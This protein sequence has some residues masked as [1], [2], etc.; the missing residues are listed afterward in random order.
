MIV[1]TTALALLAALPALLPP[2]LPPEP[3]TLVGRLVSSIDGSPVAGA[4]VV[5]LGTRRGAMS[6]EEGNFGITEVSPGTY[7]LRI[8]QVGFRPQSH[9]IV[10][11]SGVQ[12]LGDVIFAQ[13]APPPPLTIGANTPVGPGDLEVTIRPARKHIV[14][15]DSPVFEVRI[16]NRA[17]V[18]VVLVQSVD[19]SDIGKSP[20]VTIEITGPED[21]YVLRSSGRC[22][23]TNG[24]GPGDFVEVGPGEEFD[25]YAGGC[26][27][28][29]GRFE[30]PGKFTATFRYSTTET[31][32]RRW[33]AGPWLGSDVSE[34]DR[35]IFSRVPAVVLEAK[36]SF[37]VLR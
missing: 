5:V 12:R 16:R 21:G 31:D 14:V 37:I 33:M 23:N 4:T 24:V 2:T 28:S 6:D 27:G 18:P 1:R 10:V 30:R 17:S 29:R 8:V 25:P 34:S 9:E 35:E 15:G 20:K 19:G 11:T 22:G 7:T 3:A 36:T 32:P 13:P 26:I